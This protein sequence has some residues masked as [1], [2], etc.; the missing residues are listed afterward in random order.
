M[1]KVFNY[2]TIF[3][4]LF[5]CAPSPYVTTIKT[6]YESLTESGFYHARRWYA[7]VASAF[8]LLTVIG[9]CWPGVLRLHSSEVS[10]F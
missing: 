10:G 8:P 4:L 9:R 6:V 5:G 2:L 7:H 1:K 3:S